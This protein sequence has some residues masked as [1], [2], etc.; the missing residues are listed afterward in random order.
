MKILIADSSSLILLAKS[1]VLDSL[2]AASTVLVPQAVHD[3]VCSQHMLELFPD[4]ALISAHVRNGHIHVCAVI[5]SP[6][7]PLTLGPGE[8]QAIWLFLQEKADLLLTDDSKAMRVCRM[9]GIPYAA[10]PRIVVDL[11]RQRT[12]TL[13]EG[14]EAL[15]KL[16]VFGRYAPDVIGAALAGIAQ[17]GEVI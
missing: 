11:V 12:M 8:S 5:H 14:R 2:V 16:S 1:G 13:R 10:S 7:L 6:P 17:P 4:A 3:E 15:E 9:L